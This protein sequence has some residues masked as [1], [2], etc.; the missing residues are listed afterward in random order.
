MKKRLGVLVL[1]L[2]A[3]VISAACASSTA[4]TKPGQPDP[5]GHDDTSGALSVNWARTGQ[6]ATESAAGPLASAPVAPAAR[7]ALR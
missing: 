2:S 7:R 4:T 5:G 1:T 3:L 6:L